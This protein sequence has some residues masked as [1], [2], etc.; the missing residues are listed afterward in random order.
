MSRVL[1]VAERLITC[2]HNVPSAS[3]TQKSHHTYTACLHIRRDTNA[4]ILKVL[5]QPN[6]EASTWI[7]KPENYTSHKWCT[8]PLPSAHAL[9]L[10]SLKRKGHS[11]DLYAYQDQ[12][13]K[14]TKPMPSWFILIPPLLLLA[15]SPSLGDIMTRDSR[16]TLGFKVT[17]L[18][19]VAAL[20]LRR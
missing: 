3:F 16:G 18:V 2:L 15:T 20:A 19:G 6:T 9:F 7:L 1:C 10:F 5:R 8:A 17:G 12:D 11:A 14:V 4:L 13:D